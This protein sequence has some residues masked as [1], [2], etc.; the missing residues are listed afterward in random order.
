[1]NYKIIVGIV[2]FT[3]FVTLQSEAQRRRR[4]PFEQ[5]STVSFGAG[6]SS[7]VGELAPYRTP[8]STLF[9]TM[10][11]NVNAAYTKHFTPHLA[12]RVGFTWARILGDDEFFNRSGSPSPDAYVRN[13]HFRN[14]LKEFSVI[15]IYQ[16]LGD[17]RSPNRRARFTPYIFAGIALLAH[18]P[19]AMVPDSTSY[20]RY[21]KNKRW[22]ALQ[23]LGTEGQ[24]Q[25]G[26]E[27]PYSLV[28]Y[29]IPFGLGFTWK[30]NDQWNVG[31]EGGFRFSGSDFLDDASGFYP[32]PD[33]LKNDMARAMSNRTLEKI[34]ARTGKDRTAMVSRIVYPNEPNRDPFAGGALGGWQQGDF[35]GSPVRNDTYILSSITVTYVLP[36]KIKCPPIR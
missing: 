11:W 16:F 4:T 17:G 34:S 8:M 30:I 15:G 12:A 1:M 20:D 14:D 25:P 35:R 2:L 27:K 10:R 33:I 9:K 26:F 5:Y 36:T 24:G 28:T 19:K 13:L 31:V 6:T 22:I 3:L 18:N 29:S 21:P 32:N 7:Y 23:P